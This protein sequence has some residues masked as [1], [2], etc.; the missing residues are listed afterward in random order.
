MNTYELK[1]FIIDNGK[2]KYVLEKLKCHSIRNYTKELRA[3]I[4]AHNNKTALAINKETLSIKLFQSDNNIVRGDLL[5]LIMHLKN[6]TFPAANKYLHEILGI[7]YTKF[8]IKTK[9]K[10]KKDPLEIFTQI[11]KRHNTPIN[12]YEFEL[13]NEDILDDYIPYTHITWFREGIMPWTSDEFAIG[14]S[15]ERKR[16]IIPHRYWC[17]NKNDYLGIFGRTTVEH[18]ELFDIPKFIGIKPYPK[19]MNLYGLQENY[20][21]I[22]KFGYVV[23]FEAEKSTLKRHSLNDKT[24]VSICSHE[25]SN[26]QVKILIGLDVEIIIAMDKDISINHIRSMCNKFYNIRNISYIYDK[27]E[28][29]KE[30]DSPADIKNK[31]YQFLLKHRI[32]FDEKERKKYL[33]E[34]N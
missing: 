11:R 14:Y 3:G 2:L 25:L 29:L 22:Q 4:P 20:E 32:V 28:L 33:N 19:S 34:K 10:I 17:G 15:P 24:C 12:A 21:H 30:K 13:H 8:N 7:K 9:D 6:I 31:F 23:V 16:I 26:E 1:Q 18:Y 5:T 27:W